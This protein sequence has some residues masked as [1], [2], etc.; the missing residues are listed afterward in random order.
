MVASGGADGF[1]RVYDIRSGTASPVARQNEPIKRVRFMEGPQP[2]LAT[3][4]TNTLQ[5]ND[6]RSPTPMATVNLPER[7]Y[8]MD[9]KKNLLVVATSERSLLLFDLRH[10]STLLKV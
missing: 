7:C 1:A 9:L 10:P 3:V 4:G 6:A 8:S 5:Y 2:I